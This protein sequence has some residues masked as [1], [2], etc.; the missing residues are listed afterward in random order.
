[1]NRP[2]AYALRLAA[3]ALAAMAAYE[4]C[5]LPFQCNRV[6]A[7]VDERTQAAMHMTSDVGART[8]AEA[9]LRA[10]DAV[11][12]G[13]RSN[14]DIHLLRAANAEVKRAV[15]DARNELTAAIATEP[16][17]EI[18]QRRAMLEIEQ[19]D[20]DAAVRDY[21]VFVRFYPNE[22]GALGPELQSRV[23]TALAASRPCVAC[24]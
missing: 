16:R 11:A 12:A 6:I 2:A 19:R 3:L 21:V 7:E 10:L 22:L 1:M 8:T 15:A 18:Y 9:N 5:V 24:I 20:I 17:P 13:C 4:W 23:Q 14:V